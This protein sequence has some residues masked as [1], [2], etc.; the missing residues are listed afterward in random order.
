MPSDKEILLR[1]LAKVCALQ[2]QYGKT[3]AELD[4][5]VEGFLWALGDYPVE[6]II[7][8]IGKHIRKSPTIPTPADIEKIINPPRP[9]PDWAVYVSIK[10]RAQ[11]GRW[12][13]QDER[14]FLSE[15]E[16]YA[17]EHLAEETENFRNAQLQIDRYKQ[18]ESDG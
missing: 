10:K 6:K 13:Y 2:Q 11:E 5:L 18:I 9:K 4:T 3:E 1:T 8:A 12:I 17:K 16:T 14:D 15:C 7:D